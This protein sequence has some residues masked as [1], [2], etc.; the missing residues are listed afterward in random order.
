[1]IMHHTSQ[2]CSLVEHML[3][4]RM[5]AIGQHHAKSNMSVIPLMWGQS[6]HGFLK[7]VNMSS[8]YVSQIRVMHSQTP[9]CAQTL[10]IYIN[11]TCFCKFIDRTHKK[12][13]PKVFMF[14][15]S[16]V[17]TFSVKS[18][19]SLFLWIASFMFLLYIDTK[20]FTPEDQIIYYLMPHEVLKEPS[21][22]V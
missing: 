16:L 22:Q 4:I 11:K 17:N 15:P 21:T 8:V 5:R 3:T 2:P 6:P 1:M 7:Q 10:P 9:S 19:S 12:P 18:L 20:T 13:Q 14:S